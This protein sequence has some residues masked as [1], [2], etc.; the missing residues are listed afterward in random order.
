MVDHV[1]WE[2]VPVVWAAC[3]LALAVMRRRAVIRNRK[4]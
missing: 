2:A 4:P 3:L 1:P